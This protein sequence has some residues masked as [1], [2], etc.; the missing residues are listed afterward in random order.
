MKNA[1]NR[2]LVVVD[3]ETSGTNPFMHEAL[4]LAFV[5]VGANIPPASFYV[6]H[7]SIVWS[8]FARRNFENFQRTWRQE[9]VSA[10][11]TC[12]AIEQYLQRHF[13]DA[14]VTLVG[15]NIGFDVAFLRKL[16]F[17]GGR[18]QLA[19]VSH[20]AVDTHTLLY[21][22]AM[23]G[24][25]PYEAVT[26]DGAFRYFNIEIAA[27]ARHTAMGDALATRELLIRILDRLGS[28]R[29]VAHHYGSAI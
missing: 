1:S 3:I 14:T 10:R 24:L 27:E 16:A 25:I 4:A 17:Q 23:Q 26:S 20:R 21:V 28:Q 18:D 29:L 11:R 8:D 5:P 12:E 22:L 19:G 9:A 2:H 6:S 13:G 15:H 7:E